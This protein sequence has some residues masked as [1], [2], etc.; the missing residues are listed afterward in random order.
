MLKYWL[1]TY[2]TKILV[3]ASSPSVVS[4]LKSQM[5]EPTDY[6]SLLNY[7]KKNKLRDVYFEMIVIPVNFNMATK[8]E[9][10]LILKELLDAGLIAINLERHAN[11]VLA[12]RTAQATNMILDKEATSNDDL[13]EAMSLAC[14][15]ITINRQQ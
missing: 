12:L 11:L 1:N 6:L 2:N 13:L 10:L 4:A 14:K 15:R 3:D 5:G 7:R 8:K 9:M